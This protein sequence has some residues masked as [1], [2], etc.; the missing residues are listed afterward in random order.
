[1]YYHTI[2]YH[3]ISWHAALQCMI[4]YFVL[5]YHIFLLVSSNLK[6]ASRDCQACPKPTPLSPYS[7]L[8]SPIPSLGFRVKGLKSRGLGFRVV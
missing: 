6:Q 4:R 8:T 2:S 7:F 1:M 3:T 5:L